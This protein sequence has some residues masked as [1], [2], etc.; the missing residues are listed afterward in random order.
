MENK[1]IILAMTAAFRFINPA[2]LPT[3][4]VFASPSQGTGTSTALD[5]SGVAQ[6]HS[7]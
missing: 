6:V 5:I 1:Q 3:T 4:V 2:D 7:N